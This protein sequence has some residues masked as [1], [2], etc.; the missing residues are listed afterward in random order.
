M[1]IRY[2]PAAASDRGAVETLLKSCRL[3]MLD[4]ASPFGEEFVV[5]TNDEGDIL[6]VA[7]LE[8]F[9]SAALLRSVAVQEHQRG[10]GIGKELA[11]NRMAWAAKKGVQDLYL[12][13]NDAMRYWSSFGFETIERPAAPASIRTSSEWA[14]ACPSTATAMRFVLTG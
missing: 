14:G 7:G 6:G 5:A 9:G 13:T 4:A 12:L 3:A 2:R 10:R 11:R 8:L 1:T